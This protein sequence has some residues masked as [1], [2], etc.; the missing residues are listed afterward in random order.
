[1]IQPNQLLLNFSPDWRECSHNDGYETS[2]FVPSG[3][4]CSDCDTLILQFIPMPPASLG[5]MSAEWAWH[6]RDGKPW[7]SEI[8]L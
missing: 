2:A 1:M 5:Y 7:T 4:F 6:H 3:V 8:K